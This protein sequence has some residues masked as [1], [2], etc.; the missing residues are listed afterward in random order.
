MVCDRG[1]NRVS[2]F[3]SAC[4]IHEETAF[5]G[6]TYNSLSWTTPQSRDAERYGSNLRDSSYRACTKPHSTER[7][8]YREDIAAGTTAH[9]AHGFSLRIVFLPPLLLFYLSL[10]GHG[11]F[12]RRLFTWQSSDRG[13][14]VALALFLR[15]VVQMVELQE[16]DQRET[17]RRRDFP[18]ARKDT[19]FGFRGLR[20]CIA[21]RRRKASSNNRFNIHSS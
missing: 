1:K 2:A 15:R 13:S 18:A 11:S 6:G 17:R 3:A 12:K 20:T 5:G 19:L 16:R 9:A 10:R 21:R 7:R 4:D 14:W 8:Q